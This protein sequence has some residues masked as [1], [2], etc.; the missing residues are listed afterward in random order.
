MAA[1][2]LMIR[3]VWRGWDFTAGA[4]WAFLL[5]KPQV[6]AIFIIPLLLKKKYKTIFI[7]AAICA[8][9][10]VPPAIYT[11]T[12]PV[13]LLLD[14]FSNGGSSYIGG[15]ALFHLLNKFFPLFNGTLFI[16]VNVVLAFVL[17]VVMTYFV[18]KEKKTRCGFLPLPSSF[19]VWLITSEHPTGLCVG[20]YCLRRRW[21]F[22]EPTIGAVA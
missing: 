5:C 12:S 3:A 22:F 18:R 1:I 21:K 11:K 2:L 9:M 10:S 15:L 6:G 17:C 19:H 7:A 14:M 13:A 16:T 8:V 20:W 4:C